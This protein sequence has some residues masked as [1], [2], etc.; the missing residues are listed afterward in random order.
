MGAFR[1]ALLTALLPGLFTA[2]CG[3]APATAPTSTPSA[4]ETPV[5][6]VPVA[7]F[8]DSD[9]VLRSG[10]AGRLVDCDGP[11]HLGS[12]GSNV[13]TLD[14]GADTPEDGLRLFTDEGLF[15]VP[16]DGYRPAH[17]DEQRALFVYEVD[18]RPRVAVVVAVGEASE[19]TMHR[20]GWAMESFATCDAAEYGPETDEYL[21]PKVWLD[22]DGKRVPTTQVLTL[23]G[24]EHCDTQSVTFLHYGR[25]EQFVRDPEGVL[26]REQL[27][28]VYEARATL[29]DDAHD[30]GY[31]R[32]DWRLWIDRHGEAA[33]LV[34]GETVE[35]WPAAV[36]PIACF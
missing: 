22:A 34:Q 13:G 28:G 35:R 16:R 19:Q 27:K 29:P 5:L 10:A 21:A 7:D 2:G 6:Y 20:T 26:P 17:Q 4:D 31:H 30:T 32:D 18:G 36:P 3:D 15:S 1:V 12:T 11:V 24:H 33:Y 9:A 8:D 25:D 23:N 14:V